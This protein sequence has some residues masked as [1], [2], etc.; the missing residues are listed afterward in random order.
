ML[1][2]WG[3][4]WLSAVSAWEIVLLVE[5]RR[6]ELDTPIEAWVTRFLDRPGVEPVP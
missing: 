3:T 1:A 5:N 4:V 6:I 2:E